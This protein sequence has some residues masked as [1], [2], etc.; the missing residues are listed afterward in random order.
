M[1]HPFF[2]HI[3][4]CLHALA[5]HLD[6]DCIVYTR[7]AEG[8]KG[9]PNR[10]SETM[11]SS[12]AS[13]L[14]PFRRVLVINLDRRPERWDFVRRQLVERAG[15]P[16]S[17]IER[18][19]AVE[20]RAVNMDRLRACGLLSRLG[21]RRLQEPVS[22]QIWGLDLNPGAV[23]CALSHI[24]LW[25][26]IVSEGTATASTL[27]KLSYLVVE[28]D[29]LFP[30]GFLTACL[31]RLAHVPADW[32]LLYLSG[33]DTANECPGLVV[34]PGVSRVPQFHRTTNAYAVTVEGARRLLHTCVPLTFQLDT[35]MTRNVFTESRESGDS[36]VGKPCFVHD[37][38]SYTLQP[39]L[40]VQATR[41][42]SDIQTPRS[43]D[44]SPAVA[45]AEEQERCRVA[46]WTSVPD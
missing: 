12:L 34:A 5:Y 27:T 19:S 6:L 22:R 2:V 8:E 33:L 13:E 44:W 43:P 28:D 46:G 29:S 40:V 30:Q 9:G 38:V 31:A 45:Q 39:P 32:Q 15:L 26:R 4:S 35:M 16:A 3:L 17:C 23:G 10:K 24:R 21:W 7:V 1:H 25:S 36:V 41:F 42:G 18:V 37:P 20:G 14:L 11:K